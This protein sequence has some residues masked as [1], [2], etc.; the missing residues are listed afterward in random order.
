MLFS[1][2]PW[3]LAGGFMGPVSAAGLG[4]L[5]G[6][7]RGLWDTHSLFSLLEPVILAVLFSVAVRQRYRN[8]L[9]RARRHA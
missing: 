7:A 2:L 9:Y 1:A 6:L 4:L 8:R 3:M 5:V